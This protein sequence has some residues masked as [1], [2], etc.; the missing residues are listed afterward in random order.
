M[1]S[2]GCPSAEQERPVPPRLQA[3]R[4]LTVARPPYRHDSGPPGSRAD[5]RLDDSR[6]PVP[7]PPH[8]SPGPGALRSDSSWVRWYTRVRRGWSTCGSRAGA[9]SGSSRGLVSG[10]GDAGSGRRRCTR[11][12]ARLFPGNRVL[13]VAAA[14]VAPAGRPGAFAVADVDQVPELVAGVVRAGVV[15]VVAAG[16]REG[17]EVDGQVRAVGYRPQPPGPVLAVRRRC[18]GRSRSGPPGG[19]VPGLRVRRIGLVPG[20]PGRT[21]LPGR[22]WSGLGSGCPAAGPARAAVWPAGGAGAAVR[23]GVPVLIGDGQAPGGGRVGGGVWRPWR[24]P[25]PRRWARTRPRPPAARRARAGWPAG[26]SG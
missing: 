15:P 26:W 12:W 8:P 24:G 10:D 25:G 7:A 13:E 21:C 22:P 1:R 4:R 14:G 9:G 19:P 17:F 2:R 16:D 5:L 11:R 18:S 6:S 23:G 20:G 3:P